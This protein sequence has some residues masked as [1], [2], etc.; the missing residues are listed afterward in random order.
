MLHYDIIIDIAIEYFYKQVLLEEV[1]AGQSLTHTSI[2]TAWNIGLA[3]LGNHSL[4]KSQIVTLISLGIE[5]QISVL[6]I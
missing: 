4:S 6:T 5:D 2:V 3:F 1:L